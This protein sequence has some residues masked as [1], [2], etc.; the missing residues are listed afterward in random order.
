MMNTEPKSGGA[1]FT[2]GSGAVVWILGFKTEGAIPSHR[3]EG[4]AKVEILGGTSNQT[5]FNSVLN[6]PMIDVEDSQVSIASHSAGPTSDV[7]YGLAVTSRFGGV[8]NTLSESALPTRP[9][10]PHLAFIPL[11]VDQ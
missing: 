4:G 9:G 7:G 1:A 2:W 6:I 8:T 11:Y 5:S 10:R 3:I